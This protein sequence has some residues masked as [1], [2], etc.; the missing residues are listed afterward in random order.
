MQEQT[1]NDVE[2]SQLENKFCCNACHGSLMAYPA[3]KRKWFVRCISCQANRGFVT[4]STANFRETRTWSERRE[5]ETVLVFAG[6]I[7]EIDPEP[8]PKF[9]EKSALAALGF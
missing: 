3:P 4:R 9:D 6:D 1:Y 8:K 7:F 2:K 5:M